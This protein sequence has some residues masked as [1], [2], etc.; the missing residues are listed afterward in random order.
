MRG[1]GRR[2]PDGMRRT[3]GSAAFAPTSVSGLALWLRADMGVTTVAGPK[4]SAWADQ[5]GFARD[6]AQAVDARRPGYTAS[7]ASFNGQPCL[8][9]TA[10]QILTALASLPAFA[11]G[12][13]IVMAIANTPN[14]STVLFENGTGATAN[15]CGVYIDN[16]VRYRGLYHNPLGF[17]TQFGYLAPPASSSMA[18]TIDPTVAA[19]N[20]VRVYDDDVVGA[21][22]GAAAVAGTIDSNPWSLGARS[23]LTAPATADIAEVIMYNRILTAT[24]RTAL[25]LYQQQRFG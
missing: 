25:Y 24:E 12:T 11:S 23:V 14:Q 10:A 1:F 5:S 19:A 15:G 18:V 2:L 6:F 22:I 7:S 8:N 21:S 13:T 4:V 17:F 3:D 16:P 9:Y 20:Q